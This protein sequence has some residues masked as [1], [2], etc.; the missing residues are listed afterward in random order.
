LP[1]IAVQRTAIAAGAANCSQPP[2]PAVVLPLQNPTQAEIDDPFQP[3][4]SG[5]HCRLAMPT[6]LAN[7]IQIRAVAVLTVPTC[8]VGG[9]LQ[10]PCDSARSTVGIPPFDIVPILGPPAAPTTLGIRR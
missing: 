10:T 7:A 9:V 3:T 2:L 6:G 4:G 8:T 5:L 1:I